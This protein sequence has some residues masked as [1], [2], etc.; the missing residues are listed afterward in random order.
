P[1]PFKDAMERD[2]HYLL[3]LD[4]DR[5]LSGFRSEAGLKPRAEK[6]GGWESTKLAGHTLGHY[7]SA[8]SRM[9]QDT[10]NRQFLDRVNYIVTELAEC[11]KANGNGYVAAMPDGKQVFGDV[12]QGKIKAE[13]FNLNGGWSPWYTIHKELAG[14]I[15]AYR[16]CTNAQALDAATNLADWVYDTTRNLSGEQWQ[17]MLICE[18]GG[19]NE[20]LANLY[21]L[22][23]DRRYLD[24]AEKFYDSAVL[25]PLA[26]GQD[27]LSGKHD[28]TQVPKI[29]GAARIYELTGHPRYAD[30]ARFYWQRVALNRSY[31][32]GGSGDNEGFFPTN[33]WATH[34][35][36]ATCETCCTYNIL[37]LTLHLFEWSPSAVDMDFYERA[38]YNDILASQDPD[39][40][41]FVYLMSLQP[42]GFKTY[43]T[44]ENSFW[45]CVG[46][47]MENHSRYGQAIYLHGDGSLY[48]NLFIAS[49]LSWPD[50]GLV[51]RQDTKF[52]DQD[53]TRL[54][55]RCQQPVKLALKI[56]WPDWAKTSPAIQ[57]NGKKET[58]NG[59]PDS[60]IT[61]D[62]EW[63]DGD[64]VKIRLPMSLHT[65]P[66]PGT[67]NMLALLYGPIV[68]AGE[69]GTKG[70]PADPYAQDQTKF[71]KWPPVP[72]PTLVANM[73]SLLNHIQ[74]TG[75]PLTFRTKNLGHPEDVTLV[76]FYRVPHQRYTVY[77]RVLSPTEWQQQKTSARTS[78]ERAPALLK[79][80]E[81]NPT[82]QLHSNTSE[83]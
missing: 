57:I 1:G 52:P 7:L 73:N 49:E 24:L 80:R 40:G 42:G 45:C 64:V 11:Q 79:G 72:V 38:L 31:V 56:R 16:F 3:S 27:D 76:P 10:G 22:T 29:V 35:N 74:A 58:I 78:R 13:G 75:R 54:T 69:L 32:I 6:Y 44:P 34:L 51:L 28:N 65:V 68:L 15:D 41:M 2:S 25:A 66:L 70:M 61:L 83:F 60:Y 21:G 14:L 5:L 43:S 20:A 53:T 63:H 71:V 55:L 18:Y 67:T 30:L 17:T 23:G 46:T 48:V 39:T 82:A 37:K 12:A 4:P 19:M 33:Q 62:R 8:C 77:W 81:E 59:Q 9:Y 47:G 50:E 26:A 36:A